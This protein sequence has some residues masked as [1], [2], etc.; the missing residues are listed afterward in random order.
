MHTRAPAHADRMKTYSPHAVALAATAAHSDRP[1][2][3][4]IH[5]GPD[6]RLV[7]F[8]IEPGQR[9]PPHTSTSTVMLT[10]FSGS[11]SVTGGDHERGVGPGDVIAYEP[12]ELHG[13]EATEETLIIVATIA[14][15]PGS[16]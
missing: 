11:G 1:T 13:M 6:A 5:D 4:I 9:V 7:V 16:R 8:R 14:P 3:T 15:R 2:T 12:G 10:V